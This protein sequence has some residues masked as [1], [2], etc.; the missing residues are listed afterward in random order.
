MR[1]TEIAQYINMKYVYNMKIPTVY[2]YRQTLLTVYIFLP[3][4]GENLTFLYLPGRVF[5][6]TFPII[7]TI[8]IILNNIINIIQT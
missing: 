5:L 8:V 4:H 2:T 3:G 1:R 7:R 6:L